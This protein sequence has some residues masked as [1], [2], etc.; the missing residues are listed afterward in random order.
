MEEYLSAMTDILISNKGTLDKYI[1]DAVMGFFNAPVRIEKSEYLA[2]K[3]AL[4]QQECLIELNQKWEREGIPHIAIRIGIDTGEAMVG[5]I[6]SKDRFNYTVIGDHVNLASRLEGVNKEYL[7][8]I[9]VS[10]NTYK[11]TKEDFFYRELDMIR[12]KGKIQG[13]KIYELVGYL[14]DMSIK[15][16]KYLTYESALALYYNGEYKKAQKIF[17]LN[18]EDLA[19]AIMTKRCQDALDKKI[20]VV[21]GV[22]EM[23]TK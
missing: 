14:D 18:I 17:S 1:G 12:V 9:C 2:C 3:T 11:K 22:Y 4:E 23:K 6:G 21:N 13:I 7:T 5:N 8:K 10:E 16:E 20:E 19:S 15:K